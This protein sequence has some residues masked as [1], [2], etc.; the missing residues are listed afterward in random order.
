M[1]KIL[2]FEANQQHLTHYS[3]QPS[4]SFLI[5]L[6]VTKWKGR[7]DHISHKHDKMIGGNLTDEGK[8][9]LRTLISQR[10]KK[11][12]QQEELEHPFLQLPP[13]QDSL[14]IRPTNKTCV[15][16]CSDEMLANIVRPFPQLFPFVYFCWLHQWKL[17]LKWTWWGLSGPF[18]PCAAWPVL[19]QSSQGRNQVSGAKF[20]IW[21]VVSTKK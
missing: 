13:S 2:I 19:Y 20:V 12:G 15:S 10:L 16:D 11:I 1:G 7:L 5:M 9:E 14:Y 17:D 21:V 8:M 4:Y 6:T 18:A 3:M